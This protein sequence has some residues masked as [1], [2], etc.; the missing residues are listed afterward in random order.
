M[1]GKHGCSDGM[2]TKASNPLQAYRQIAARRHKFMQDGKVPICLK[3][4]RNEI[5]SYFHPADKV[6]DIATRATSEFKLKPNT[7]KI[8]GLERGK[9]ADL[10]QKLMSLSTVRRWIERYVSASS[11]EERSVLMAKRVLLQVV[12][13]REENGDDDVDDGNNNS[14]FGLGFSRLAGSLMSSSSSPSNA[15][16]AAAVG[17]GVGNADEEDDD[18]DLKAAIAMSL[19][20]MKCDKEAQEDSKATEAAASTL[21]HR[22]PHSS[23]PTNNQQS[24]SSFSSSSSSSRYSRGEFEGKSE[25]RGGEEEDDDQPRCRICLEG[26]EEGRLFSPCLC[27]GSMQMV[28]VECLNEWRRSSQNPHSYYQCQQCHYQYQLRRAWFAPILLDKRFVTTISILVMTL[29]MLLVAAVASPFLHLSKIDLALKLY[30]VCDFWPWWTTHENWAY[31]RVY[32]DF[33]VTGMLILGSIGFL[34]WVYDQYR[35]HRHH[36]DKWYRLVMLAVSFMGLQSDFQTARLALGLGTMFT[37]FHLYSLT[38]LRC[39]AVAQTWGES[40]LEVRE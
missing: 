36:P 37:L 32:F 22:R 39:S 17:R 10:E 29:M 19:E 20:D 4:M 8:L 3:M 11:E 6:R 18:P 40:I 1:E 31:Y 16:A 24:S 25:E 34:H 35:I 30:R 38:K 13:T 23:P 5:V 2:E 26:P 12:G 27:R 33:L 15:T 9:K 21:R 7:V 14:G 28:H